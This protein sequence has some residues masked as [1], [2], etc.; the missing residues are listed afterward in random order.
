MKNITFDDSRKLQK[1]E[2]FQYNEKI[3]MKVFLLFQ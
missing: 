2:L 1:N 3:K